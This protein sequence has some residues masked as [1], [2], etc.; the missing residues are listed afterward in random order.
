MTKTY[1]KI[2]FVFLRS[3]TCLESYDG[4]ENDIFPLWMYIAKVVFIS[5]QMHHKTTWVS[6]HFMRNMSSPLLSVAPMILSGS[7]FLANPL[8]LSD[9]SK[10]VLLQ[11]VLSIINVKFKFL[12]L[13]TNT[14]LYHFLLSLRLALFCFWFISGGFSF[15]G[16]WFFHHSFLRLQ[17]CSN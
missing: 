12:K 15:Y 6:Y 11:S 5:N 17:E 13:I 10:A 16:F 7:R 9:W 1:F 4:E 2:S 3:N 8:G 14:Q